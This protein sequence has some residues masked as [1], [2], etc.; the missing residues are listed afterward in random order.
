MLG[1]EKGKDSLTSEKLKAKFPNQFDLV[2]S[3]IKCARDIIRRGQEPT[4]N[5]ESVNVAFLAVEMLNEDKEID[6]LS[7]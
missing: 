4:E 2:N 3:A 6:T 1:K 7:R 5:G